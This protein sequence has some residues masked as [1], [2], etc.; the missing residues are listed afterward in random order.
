MVVLLV[1]LVLSVVLSP[2]SE[3]MPV[4]SSLLNWC[5]LNTTNVVSSNPTQPR[6]IRYNIIWYGLS[7]ICERSVVFSG[8]CGFLHQYNWPPRYNWN[9]VESGVKHHNPNRKPSLRSS[10]R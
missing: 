3:E 10:Q 6:C 4:S 9:I 7:V 1:V 8:Y 2:L 5:S